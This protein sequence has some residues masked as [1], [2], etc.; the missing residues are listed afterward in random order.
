MWDAVVLPAPGT[1]APHNRSVPLRK[2]ASRDRQPELRPVKTAKV[3]T[4]H[5]CRANRAQN[6]WYARQKK[7][8]MNVRR[9]PDHGIGQPDPVLATQCHCS[10]GDVVLERDDDKGVQ[11][12]T[13]LRLH[14]LTCA[15]H[16]LHPGHDADRLFSVSSQFRS[17]L[18][19]GVEEIDQDVGVE[20]GF[21]H[22]L[23]TFF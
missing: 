14:V 19:N 3:C 23:R 1:G 16:H 13:G 11:K 10:F 2:I 12:G 15:D 9:C 8:R 7:H 17:R 22:S 5:G 20:K 4:A 6:L 18:R 21:H